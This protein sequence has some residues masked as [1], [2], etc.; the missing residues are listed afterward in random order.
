MKFKNQITMIDE[1]I[2]GSKIHE[3]KITGGLKNKF[4]LN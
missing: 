1:T 2:D 4:I 3:I